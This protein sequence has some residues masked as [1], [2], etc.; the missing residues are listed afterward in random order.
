[1]DSFRRIADVR[2][3]M[4]DTLQRHERGEA[5]VGVSLSYSFSLGGIGNGLRET[6]LGSAEFGREARG[7]NWPETDIG[8]TQ[9][10]RRSASMHI[11][12]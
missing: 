12:P 1:M 2:V 5:R 8:E 11:S 7:G 6:R 10:R 4:A 9:Y 3:F